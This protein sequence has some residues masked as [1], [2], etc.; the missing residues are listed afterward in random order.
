MD[1]P[2]K[3]ESFEAQDETYRP[4]REICLDDQL[5]RAKL[6]LCLLVSELRQVKSEM[7]DIFVRASKVRT[8]DMEIIDKKEQIRQLELAL[9]NCQILNKNYKE[10]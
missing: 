1:F 6:D 3:F 4:D 10:T 2:S 9:N 8:L 5:T 7:V